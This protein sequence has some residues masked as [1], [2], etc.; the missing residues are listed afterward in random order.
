MT[1]HEEEEEDEGR[2]LSNRSDYDELDQGPILQNSIS[3]ENF[4][5]TNFQSQ[6]LDKVKIK[7]GGNPFLTTSEFTTTIIALQ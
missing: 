3:A 2:H 1:L 6:I 7:T 5:T 4:F